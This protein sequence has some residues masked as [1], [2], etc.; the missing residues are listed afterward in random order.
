MCEWVDFVTGF[1]CEGL[2]LRADRLTTL[3]DLVVAS[4]FFCGKNRSVGI[5]LLGVFAAAWTAVW[6]SLF[7]LSLSRQQ[8]L[9]ALSPARGTKASTVQQVNASAMFSKYIWCI[10]TTYVHTYIQHTFAFSIIEEPAGALLSSIV[11]VVVDHDI[12]AIVVEDAADGAVPA[13]VNANVN[14]IVIVIVNVD[15][16]TNVN[17]MVNVSV[18]VIVNVDV[19]INVKVNVI[20]DVVN[21][22]DGQGQKKNRNNNITT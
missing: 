20:V 19:D 16:D 2:G 17:V 15:A 18:N 9:L 11:V 1:I 6:R 22:H 8:L 10:R 14:A 13:D 5:L 3:K 4:M 12:F 7:L 21:S